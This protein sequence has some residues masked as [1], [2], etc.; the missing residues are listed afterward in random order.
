MVEGYFIQVT[1]YRRHRL[2]DDYMYSGSGDR[3][4]M[5]VY[6]SHKTNWSDVTS[7]YGHLFNWLQV[8]LLT[9]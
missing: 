6:N 3:L 8:T 7:Y 2:H 9:L 5:T 1:L 4:Q